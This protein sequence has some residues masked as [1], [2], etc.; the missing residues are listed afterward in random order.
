MSTTM[1]FSGRSLERVR[2]A[3]DLAIAELQHQLGVCP[4]VFK[5]VDEIEACSTEIEE[6]RKLAKRIDR[7]LK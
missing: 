5:Y 1:S 2:S 4:D 7:R 3:I 6:L